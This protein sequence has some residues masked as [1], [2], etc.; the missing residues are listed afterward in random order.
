MIEDNK[1]PECGRYA[2]WDFAIGC[3]RCEYCGID[4]CGNQI[5]APRRSW[6]EETGEVF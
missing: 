2:S 4:F 6:G 3:Y 5:F 1:C